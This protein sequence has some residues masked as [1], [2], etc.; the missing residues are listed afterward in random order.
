MLTRRGL[1]GGVLGFAGSFLLPQKMES[2]PKQVFVVISFDFVTDSWEK[3][4]EEMFRRTGR[5]VS[6]RVKRWSYFDD[7]D[8]HSLSD[9]QLKSGFRAYN[10]DNKSHFF[11]RVD[12]VV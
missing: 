10:T 9:Q 7:V 4:K 11:C 12:A 1:F 8:F 3:V 6:N 5:R 2:K